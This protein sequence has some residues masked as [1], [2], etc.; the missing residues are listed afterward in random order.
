VT[1]GYA[2]PPILVRI[3]LER[4]ADQLEELDRIVWRNHELDRDD[5]RYR[6]GGMLQ[7]ALASPSAGTSDLATPFLRGAVHALSGAQLL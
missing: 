3:A 4:L 1:A 6:V 7:L 2:A 5:L